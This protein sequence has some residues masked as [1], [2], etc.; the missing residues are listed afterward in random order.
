[1]LDLVPAG[2]AR[3]VKEDGEIVEPLAPRQV[4]DA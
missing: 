3:L 2:V 1:V 4:P